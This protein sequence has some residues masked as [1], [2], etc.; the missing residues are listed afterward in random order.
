MSSSGPAASPAPQAAPHQ[1]SGL[2]IRSR[3]GASWRHRVLLLLVLTTVGAPGG[4]DLSRVE[5]AC[6]KAFAPGN[7]AF[8]ASYGG[9]PVIDNCLTV[10]RRDPIARV[11]RVP[12]QIAVDEAFSGYGAGAVRG[13]VLSCASALRAARRPRRQSAI[14]GQFAGR[15]CFMRDVRFCRQRN[16]R[17]ESVRCRDSVRYLRR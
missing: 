10:H 3:W 17:G 6:D 13:T 8:I 14:T 16:R 1:L 12:V 5:A 9:G 11:D 7:N 2:P 15:T 4:R